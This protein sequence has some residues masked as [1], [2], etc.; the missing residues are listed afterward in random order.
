MFYTYIFLGKLKNVINRPFLTIQ[1]IN[2]RCVKQE[3]HLTNLTEILR[4]LFQL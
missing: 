1:R 4:D 3:R 2:G